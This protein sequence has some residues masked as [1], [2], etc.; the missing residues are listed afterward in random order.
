MLKG[1]GLA[2]VGIIITVSA[3]SFTMD[4]LLKMALNSIVNTIVFV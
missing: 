2:I 1:L 3:C 4:K